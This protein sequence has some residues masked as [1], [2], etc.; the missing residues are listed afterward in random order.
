MHDDVEVD[1]EKAIMENPEV[2][3]DYEGELNALVESEATLSEEFKEKT[4]VI[5]ESAMKA[6]LSEEIT[7]LEEN[8]AN[9]LAEEI[10][11][12]KS[13]LVEKVDSYLNYVVEQWMKTINWLYSLVYVLKS[14]KLS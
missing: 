7:K 5:F 4:A 14:L 9:E 11:A 8:Y 6:K 1:D 12:T 13:D 10:K 3:Y 2:A